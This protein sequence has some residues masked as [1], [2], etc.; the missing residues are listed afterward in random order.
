MGS[1]LP[2][3]GLLLSMYNATVS[4]FLMFAF[5]DDLVHVIL[6]VLDHRGL[7]IEFLVTDFL[8]KNLKHPFLENGFVGVIPA[9]LDPFLNIGRN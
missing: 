6:D 8:R 2:F 3:L 1:L 5:V 9:P 4:F 7:L